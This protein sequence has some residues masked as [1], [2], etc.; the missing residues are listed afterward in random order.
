M[1]YQFIQLAFILFS[2]TG[3][4]RAQS[5]IPDCPFSCVCTHVTHTLT[6]SCDS[7]GKVISLPSPL[8]TPGLFA[9]RNVI[10]Q[11][12]GLAQIPV[13]LNS[14]P[15]VYALQTLDLSSNSLSRI[16]AASFVCQTSLTTLDLSVNRLGQLDENA[17]DSLVNLVTLDLSYNRLST[18]PNYVF[19]NKLGRLQN[20]YL[21]FNFLTS[22]DPWYFFMK[23]ILVINLYGNQISSFTNNI[24]FKVRENGL[25]PV[26]FKWAT[27][28]D[29]RTN[30]LTKFDDSI[31]S[32]EQFFIFFLVLLQIIINLY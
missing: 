11:E 31:L 13:N 25:L 15:C 8:L 24:N 32:L 9:I 28:I 22:L 10:V 14:N 27:F 12:S 3:S 18:L 30:Q 26:S 7:T 4:L 19:A 17:F 5:A 6:V 1:N 20:L 21:Q 29:L 2:V 23:S 16:A